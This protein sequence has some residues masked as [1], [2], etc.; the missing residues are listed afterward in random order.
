MGASFS[1]IQDIGVFFLKILV[2][3]SFVAYAACCEATPRAPEIVEA[4]NAGKT[5]KTATQSD[6]DQC[7]GT[8]Q[9]T[10]VG[11]SLFHIFCLWAATLWAALQ[12]AVCTVL[13]RKKGH[14]MVFFT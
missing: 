1:S 3:L 8:N 10:F 7:K 11:G 4:D 6:A 13:S 12:V 5:I 9:R 2:S 14:V